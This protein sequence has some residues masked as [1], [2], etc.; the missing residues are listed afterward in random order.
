M[1]PPIVDSDAVGTGDVV[2]EPPS[3]EGVA[4]GSASLPVAAALGDQQASLFGLGCRRPGTAKVTL[5]T[6]AFILAQAGYAPPAPPPGVLGSCAWRL[7]GQ[8]SFALEGFVPAAGSAL[9]WFSSLGMIPP[10]G[11]LDEV[12][13]QAG[14]EDG[15]VACI[16]ALQGL[17]TPSWNAGIRAA[18]LGISRA[19]TRPQVARAL[20]DGV[21][22]Q[23]VDA[24]EAISR[25]MP[26]ESVLLDGGMSRSDWVVRR[27]AD[28]A[29]VE[30]RRASRGEA[31]V[32]GAAMMAGL[33]AGFW[34]DPEEFPEL[35]TDLTAVPHIGAAE[36]TAR[37]DRWATA[38]G[39]AAKWQPLS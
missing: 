16:P 33:A 31:T 30:V 20:V 25:A 32:I 26:L 4:R 22:H 29:G 11:E 24:L 17:G 12:L 38:V 3:P 39:V 36:R 7:R 15:T 27:L 9:D 21:L 1:L 14:P 23:V 37:R 5:G 19:T 10:A 2:R 34:S 18:L 8:P 6:G 13:A 28:L 35:E